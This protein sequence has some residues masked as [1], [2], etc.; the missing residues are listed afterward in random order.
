MTSNHSP[1]EV[2]HALD[3]ALQ[4]TSYSQFSIVQYSESPWGADTRLDKS[5][6]ELIRLVVDLY[7]AAAVS[8]DAS[9]AYDDLKDSVHKCNALSH[10]LQD[11]GPG[12]FL[13]ELNDAGQQLT[14]HLMVRNYLAII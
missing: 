8:G 10:V 5:S 7:A 4:R 11:S 2:L 6:T 13:D 9:T 12:E 3:E 1:L 14:N